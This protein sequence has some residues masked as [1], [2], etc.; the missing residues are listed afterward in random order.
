MCIRDR[1]NNSTLLN[2]GSALW[3]GYYARQDEWNLEH[4][5]IRTFLVSTEANKV[6]FD[7]IYSSNIFHADEK[8][9]TDY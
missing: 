3:L 2:E 4:M 8:M 1:I 6:L 9:S 7:C 5:S